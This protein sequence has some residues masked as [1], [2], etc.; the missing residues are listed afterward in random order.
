MF[1]S[2]TYRRHRSNDAHNDQRLTRAYN[3]RSVIR[4]LFADDVTIVTRTAKIYD[5]YS[6]EH[7]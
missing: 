2:D 5:N 3:I 6:T 1:M 7:K 4:Y